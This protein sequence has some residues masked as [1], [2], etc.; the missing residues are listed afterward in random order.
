MKG[1]RNS[2]LLKS[3][4]Q[5]K[6]NQDQNHNYHKNIQQ[7]AI[8]KQQILTFYTTDNNLE[9]DELLSQISI[10]LAKKTNLKILVIDMNPILPTMDHFFNVNKFVEV[11]DLY[12]EEYNTGLKIAYGALEKNLFSSNFLKDIIVKHN[13]YS[14]LH[15]LTGIYDIN[16]YEA[17]EEKHYESIIEAA[18][19]IYDVIII[20]TNPSISTTAT[21]VALKKATK[22]IVIS[23]ANYTYARNTNFTLNYLKD[24]FKIPTDKFNI[25]INNVSSNT[26]DKDILTKIFSEYEILG[27]IPF[28]KERE[29]YIN[30]KGSFIT[31]K[32]SKKD[33]LKYLEIIENLGYITKSSFLDK[34]F[35]KKKIINGIIENE[36]DLNSDN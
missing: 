16:L 1:K 23:N 8:T 5:E 10:L 27:F 25:L 4:E 2:M 7:Q 32:D 19:E 18:K 15:I 30:K 11:K 24:N 35:N 21:Y 12:N 31:S 33:I 17:M 29:K 28:N 22:V 20:N 26:L 3:I 9:K 6:L 13:K 34:I 14:N 36:M